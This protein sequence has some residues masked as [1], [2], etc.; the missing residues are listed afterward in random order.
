VVWIF[1][2]HD[3]IAI[4]IPIIDVIIVIRRDAEIKIV[5]PEAVAVSAAK[6][7][8]VTPSKAAREA[9]V[10]PSMIYMIMGIVTARIVADPRVIVVNVRHLRMIRLIAV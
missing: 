5:E 3:G 6:A 1:V 2:D 4:P 8:L 7:I 10:F 9:A